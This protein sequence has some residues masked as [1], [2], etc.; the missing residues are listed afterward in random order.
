MIFTPRPYQALLSEH[1]I[2]HSRCA[3]WAG[4]G[5]GKTSGSLH[6]LD[7]L[8]LVE[9][10]APTL[11]IAPLRVARSVWPAECVKWE[12]FS[13]FK[14]SPILGGPQ[15][16]ADMASSKADIYTVNYENIPWL[17]EFFGKN[18]PFKRVISDESTKLKSFRLRQGG[19]RA[20]ALSK[21]AFSKVDRFIQL[22]G[23]PSPNGLQDLWGQMWFLDQG[24]AL[25]RSFTSFTQ[26]WFRAVNP[27]AGPQVRLEPLR[28]ADEEIQARVAPLVISLRPEDWFPDL[29]EP[30]EVTVPV[31]MPAK[32]MKHYKEMEK[33]MYTA[34]GDDP[35][36]AR[37]AAG[38]TMK[39]LQI[40]S[41][42]VYVQEGIWKTVHDEKIEALKSIV[43]EAGGRPLLVA[44]HFKHDL[45]RL[46][47][48]FPEAR[49]LD[50]KQETE[51]AWNRGEIPMLVTHPQS[52][53]HG[54]NLQDGSNII[55]FFSHWWDLELRQQVIERIGPV[56]QLQS[57][58]NRKVFI[59]NIIVNNT[60]ERVVLARHATK[61][62]V[63]DLLLEARKKVA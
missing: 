33:E 5:M 57:G 17:V 60:I 12:Q 11:V 34:L 62:S 63:Q 37:N 13:R 30:M 24:E 42:A 39:C 7:I 26:R 40:A 18:W 32:A 21:V 16:R 36:E 22:T 28:H 29:M 2:S 1:I 19:K 31:E 23:T 50:N 58:H 4:M 9:D 47:K 8:D 44:Y 25:G 38:K 59:Y 49:E 35:V 41:G 48:A 56:R 20:R 51:D 53:G 45:A 6:A 54:L 46:L 3:V 43:A 15:Q 55:V 27:Y 14:V 52:A 10:P 61:R